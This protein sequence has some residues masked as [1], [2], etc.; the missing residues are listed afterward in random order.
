M[1]SSVEMDEVEVCEELVGPVGEKQNS[2]RLTDGYE[3]RRVP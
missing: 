1:A 2:S 3:Q